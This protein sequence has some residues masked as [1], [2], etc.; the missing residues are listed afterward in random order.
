MAMLGGMLVIFVI[1]AAA[2]FYMGGMRGRK[3]GWTLGGTVFV[4]FA[5]IGAM[6]PKAPPL[7]AC[8]AGYS[9]D[10]TGKGNCSMACP[11]FENHTPATDKESN[12]YLYC[13]EHKQKQFERLIGGPEASRRMD[14]LIA[15]TADRQRGLSERDI[16]LRKI[17]RDL[18][19]K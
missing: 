16:T 2:F 9:R 10:V 14:N 18:R 7:P 3:L 11:Y 15:E 13:Q 8:E 1:A 5:A 12:Y 4:A 17:E 6:L 19:G